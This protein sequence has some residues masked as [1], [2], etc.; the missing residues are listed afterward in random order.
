MTQTQT[1]T[2]DY[3]LGFG[4]TIVETFRRYTV[5]S[6]AGHILPRLERGQRV[7]DFGCGPGNLSVGLASAVNPGEMHGVDMEESQI[8]LARSIAEAG[9]FDNAIFQVADVADLP[10][11]DGFFDVAHDHQVLMHIPDTLGALEEVKRTL[12]PGGLISCRE[13]VTLGS[14]TYPDYGVIDEAWRIFADLL[15]ADDA[16]PRM[17]R[18]LKRHLLDAGFEDI[19]VAFDYDVYGGAEDVEFIYN[20]ASQWFLADEIMDAAIKY[21][22]ATEELRDRIRDAYARWREHPGAFCALAY[23][24]AIARKPLEE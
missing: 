14:F 6:Q 12:K 18:E 10:F 13:M 9:G 16:H 5:E 19:E 3:T 11:E 4:E 7:L 21:G 1:S 17:G 23:G 20:V 15:M 24:T 22:A 8:R 2:P